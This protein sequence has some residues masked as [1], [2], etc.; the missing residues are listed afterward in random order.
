MQGSR[1]HG[2][3]YN[4]K[5]YFGALYTSLK[6]AT[7]EAEMRR[8]YTVPPDCG[9]VAAQVEM[10]LSRVIDLTSRSLLRKAGLQ[11]SGITADI[12]PATQEFGLQA[13]EMG[14]EALLVPSAAD[15][16][17]RNLVVYLDNQRPDWRV[18]LRS[19]QPLAPPV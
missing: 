9:F 1:L 10:H 7:A 6:L 19:V 3:R 4:I 13:W 15:P 11:L 8:Y 12:C 16:A 17:E 14:V 2:S 18:R 5:D